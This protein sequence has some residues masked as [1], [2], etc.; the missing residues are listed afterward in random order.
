[1]SP[2]HLLGQERRICSTKSITRELVKVDRKSLPVAAVEQLQQQK[3]CGHG[4][5]PK[6]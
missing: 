4:L 3:Y 1:M 6:E 2:G 5:Y